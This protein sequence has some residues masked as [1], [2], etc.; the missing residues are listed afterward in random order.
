MTF[1][2]YSRLPK[3]TQPFRS[4]RLP[5][6]DYGKPQKRRKITKEVKKVWVVI[7][8]EQFKMSPKEYW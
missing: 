2:K 7:G 5:W 3:E 4:Q 1:A 8:R 6:T